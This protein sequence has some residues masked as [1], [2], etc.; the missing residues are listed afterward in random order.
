MTSESRV[1]ADRREPGA[2]AA[3]PAL[4]PATDCGRG[5]P[6]RRRGGQRRPRTPSPGTLRAAAADRRACHVTADGQA[7]APSHESRVPG[8][9]ARRRA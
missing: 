6:R 8:V 3:G 4:R 5:H 7:R 2:R 1:H 9:R